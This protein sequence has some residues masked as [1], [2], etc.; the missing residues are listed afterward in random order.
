MTEHE[1]KIAVEL[2]DGMD[3]GGVED[4]V[5]RN[6]F[7]AGLGI[8]AAPKCDNRIH[9]NKT[10]LGECA[11]IIPRKVGSHPREDYKTPLVERKLDANLLYLCEKHHKLADN[12]ELADQYPAHVLRAWK[13]DHEAW[14]SQIKKEDR[15]L[16]ADLRRRFESFM[17]EVESGSAKAAEHSKKLLS[18]LLEA[19]KEHLWRGRILEASALLSQ[20]ELVLSDFGD[21]NL[22][23][24]SEIL[25]AIIIHKNEDVH[26]AK[27]RLHQIISSNSEAHDAMFEYISICNV[28][29]EPTDDADKFEKIVTELYPDDARLQILN[30]ARASENIDT[31]KSNATEYVPEISEKGLRLRYYVQKMIVYDV[32]QD[33]EKRDALLKKA[34]LE[35]PLSPR[36]D[37]FEFIFSSVDALR[38][39]PQIGELKASLHKSADLRASIASKDP[40]TIRDKV[41]WDYHE[42]ILK[43]E[44]SRLYAPDLDWTEN[45]D[46]LLSNLAGCF[47]DRALITIIGNIFSFIRVP[48]DKLK[49]LISKLHESKVEKPEAF[50]QQLFLQALPYN[51]CHHE[52]LEILKENGRADLFSLHEALQANNEQVIVEKVNAIGSDDFSVSLLSFIGD[53]ELVSKIAPKL[54]VSAESGMGV[55]FA[56]FE[57]FAKSGKHEEAIRLI[58]S[59]DINTMLPLPLTRIVKIA[60]QEK[61]WRLFVPAA[62]K[63]C[64]FDIPAEYKTELHAKLAIALQHEGDDSAAISFA[65]MAL[66][67]RTALGDQNAETIIILCANSNYLLGSADKAVEVFSKHNAPPSFALKLTEAQMLLRTQRNDKREKAAEKV[68]EGFLLAEN[69]DDRTF[70]SAFEILNGINS[71]AIAAFTEAKAGSYIKIEDLGWIYLGDPTNAL[72]AIPVS[73]GANYEAI[74]GKAA[75]ESILWPP[76]KYSKPG[77][78]RKMIYILSAIGYLSARAAEGLE[79]LAN[80]GNDAVWSVQALKEDGSLDLETLKAFLNETNKS[81]NDFFET[82]SNSVLPLGF[83][84]SIERDLAKAISKITSEDRGFIRCNDGSNA[85][86]QRQQIAAKAVIEGSPCVMDGLTALVL[87]EGNLL[88]AVLEAVPHMEA[89]MSVIRYLRKLATDLDSV[90]GSVG[91]GSYVGGNF[92]FVP[93]EENREKEFRKKL[94]DA[95]SML[96]KLPNKSI[97]R[98]FED[99]DNDEK[100]L[101]RQIPACLIDALYL[102]RNKGALLLTDDGIM[103]KAFEITEKK[104][105]P[106]NVSSLAIVKVLLEQR[107]ISFSQYLNYYSLLAGYRY[108]LLPISVGDLTDAVMP[109]TGGLVV[110]E[111][112]NIEYLRIQLTLST[113][114]GVDEAVALKIIAGFLSHLIADDTIPEELADTTFAYTIVNFF[115]Q[116]ESRQQAEVLLQVCKK[117]MGDERWQT[118]LSKR[119]YEILKRQLSRFSETYDPLFARIPTLMKVVRPTSFEPTE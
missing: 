30:A 5:K 13:K 9:D 116:R 100:S 42:L 3:S 68:I 95:A 62:K 91:R 119:K 87:A 105:P 114:Y 118:D 64:E 111:P 63:L 36:L 26:E 16:P 72:G 23:E 96:D 101:Q 39:E 65:E 84:A 45:L 108:H 4:K 76:D 6:L 31:A 57:A 37:M 94:I 28:A 25:A 33:K 40:L 110:F 56:Q 66:E 41:A 21:P 53:E 52:M 109:K 80:R 89:P 102:A 38:T 85:D 77:K 97:G 98:I 107:K 106:Q 24:Q 86:I 22:K 83:L 54:A 71:E 34:A 88:Q 10:R 49:P 115:G 18:S 35:Y 60:W 70:V 27:R 61:V 1:V 32:A 7:S 11:H 81:S 93:R 99:D 12:I 20:I 15:L 14:A 55:K 104:T 79:N 74:I 67:N 29:P 46:S 17:S 48:E 117:Q 103:P 73:S 75:T 43:C 59:M 92:K 78:T 113:A 82:Y 47:I 19:S 69:F 8:C 2:E 51:N 112:R 90:S 58:A 44:L 50:L